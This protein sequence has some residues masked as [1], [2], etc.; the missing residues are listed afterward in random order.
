MFDNVWVYRVNAQGPQW[1][2]V[3]VDFFQDN[4]PGDGTITG[5]ARIDMARDLV[6]DANTT[7]IQP[8]DSMVVSVDDPESGLT[9]DG[10]TGR[11]A[12]YCY[13]SVDG[14]HSGTTP[15]S[16]VDDATRWTV[17]GAPVVAG[18]RTWT[19]I[20]MDTVYTDAGS[21]VADRF[22]IDLNDNLF[23]P[24]DDIYYFYGALSAGGNWTYYSY[25][26]PGP[27]VVFDIEPAASYPDEVNVLPKYGLSVDNDILYVDGTDDRFGQVYFDE[28]FDQLGIL[29]EVDR[30][31]VIA[32][33]SSVGN[34][35]S[36]RV[37]AIGTQILGIYKKIIWN[38]GYLTTGWT[39][40][41]GNPGKS[42][43]T[44]FIFS[45]LEGLEVEGGIWLN[46]DNAGDIW[47][48]STGSSAIALKNKYMNFLLDNTDHKTYVNISPWLIGESGGI[49]E[50]AFAVVDT[51]VA[52]GG[53]PLIKNFDVFI[54]DGIVSQVE[55]QYHKNSASGGVGG[56]K[57][58]SISQIT[59][60][61]TVDVG[62]LLEG[63]GFQYIEDIVPTVYRIA[64]GTCSGSSSGSR[65][66]RTIRSAHVRRSLR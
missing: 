49:F 57:P 1:S 44:G 32:P 23:T 21:V 22:C 39:D 51:M 7:R 15:T 26:I 5:T 54:Q 20:N 38:T 62:F 16:Y 33:S 48:N 34:H 52:A 53:C 8:G 3:E 47:H 31:D 30:Y 50:D 58:A 11:A 45:F 9:T 60:N 27:N 24:G 65:T 29:D 14:P 63:F 13:I 64:H 43:D 18:G 61:G 2:V 42:D 4:F 17:V 25:R 41:T 59:N 55:M 46:G 19:Q 66:R 10:T 37:T 12:V 6:P 40:G 28:S 35:P 36:M 56:P